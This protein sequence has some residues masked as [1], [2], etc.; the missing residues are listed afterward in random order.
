[1]AETQERSW[2]TG[3]KTQD[4]F[5]EERNALREQRA[6]EGLY[7]TF[8]II[9]FNDDVPL[10]LEGQLNK[11]KV[12]SPTD[13]YLP[14]DVSRIVMSYD[15]R[16]RL[17]HALVIRWPEY[18]GK[19]K[20]A[21]PSK[22][23][24]MSDPQVERDVAF[25]DPIAIAYAFLEHF[26]PIFYM[27]ADKRIGTPPT[28]SKAMGGVMAFEGDLRVIDPG[29][30]E[31]NGGTVKVPILRVLKGGKKTYD[32]VTVPIADYKRNVFETQKR[33]ALQAIT[34][35]NRYWAG[36]QDQKDKINEFHRIRMRW[37]IKMGY[38]QMPAPDK[39]HWFDEAAV[40]SSLEGEAEEVESN[41][42]LCQACSAREP[43][44]DTPFCLNCNAPIDTFRTFM[45]DPEIGLRGFPVPEAWLQAL[46]GEEREIVL[47]ELARRRE[48]FEGTKGPGEPGPKRGPYKGGKKAEQAG[49]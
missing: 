36:A 44:P 33:F 32:T 28:D 46:Q 13:P 19:M 39:P 10:T 1:M 15:G 18:Y 40:V 37:A 30:L 31:H 38:A 11:Y 47:E 20:S 2:E 22:I 8:T 35:A 6:A 27:A 29:Y 5:T 9:N 3:S 17:G 12:P 16:D 4:G 21:Q 24:L 23:G 48:G 34:M 43:K 41:L 45:G 14:A 42:R 49:E 25:Y 7:K 26:S